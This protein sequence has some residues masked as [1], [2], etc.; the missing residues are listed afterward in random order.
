[1]G[2]VRRFRFVWWLQFV[3]TYDYLVVIIAVLTF[4]SAVISV[5]KAIP[6]NTSDFAKS[7]YQY[8]WHHRSTPYSALSAATIVFL[9]GLSP[10]DEQRVRRGLGY[11]WFT[12]T[13]AGVI[14]VVFSS[15]VSSSQVIIPFPAT[16]PWMG[17]GQYTTHDEMEFLVDR[18]LVRQVP[19]PQTLR[20]GQT[21]EFFYGRHVIRVQ[22]TVDTTYQAYFATTLARE[23]ILAGSDQ[24]YWYQTMLCRLKMRIFPNASIWHGDYQIKTEGGRRWAEPIQLVEYVLPS[25]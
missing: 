23:L 8:N 14:D 2:F 1:M 6:I 4:G 22:T 18:G 24:D 21:Q 9:R 17:D 20:A 13:P 10:Q 5:R 7:Y 3:S 11:M 12:T 16:G 15:K 19:W 25:P